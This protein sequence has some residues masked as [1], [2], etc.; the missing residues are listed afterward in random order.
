MEEE[1]SRIFKRWLQQA[2]RDL[3]AAAV[4]EKN[5]AY[6]WATFLAH[7]AA[8]R[9]LKAYL[10]YNDETAVFGHSIRALVL[11]CSARAS[12]FEAIADVGKLD[13]FYTAPRFPDSFAEDVP[14]Y[15]VTPEQAEV[16][17]EL[18][19]KAVDLVNKLAPE[20]S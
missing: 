3:D 10:Y 13:D 6:E 16:A 18:A 5:D 1:K 8:E 2:Q 12:A 4:L 7:Q 19:R 9:V 14:A 11:K 20:G 15:A 17:L